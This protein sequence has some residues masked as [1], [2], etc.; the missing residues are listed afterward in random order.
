MDKK[1]EQKND[2]NIVNVLLVAGSVTIALV[3]VAVVTALLKRKRKDKG[4]PLSTVCVIVVGLQYVLKSVAGGL[5]I[6]APCGNS[7]R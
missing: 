7:S 5:V 6:L 3:F 4:R 1:S 2:A